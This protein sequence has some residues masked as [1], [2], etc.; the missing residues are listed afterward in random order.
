[1]KCISIELRVYKEVAG[2]P[3]GFSYKL[4]VEE[5]RRL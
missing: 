1:M 4:L 2:R 5:T 3:T